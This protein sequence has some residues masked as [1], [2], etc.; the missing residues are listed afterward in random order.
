MEKTAHRNRGMM[1]SFFPN[2]LKQKGQL[3]HLYISAQVL[4]LRHLCLNGYQD[5]ATNPA[6]FNIRAFEDEGDTFHK[7][8][9]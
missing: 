2:G 3:G 1:K 8:K 5:Q 7:E 4:P 9:L 6:T